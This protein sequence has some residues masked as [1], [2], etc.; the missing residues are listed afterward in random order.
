MD[1]LKLAIVLGLAGAS[2]TL[3]LVGVVRGL[4]RSVDVVDVPQIDPIQTSWPAA[5]KHVARIR[6][7]RGLAVG[8]SLGLVL[9]AALCLAYTCV[10]T[11]LK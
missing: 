7:R 4:G 5:D 10:A 3:I 6:Q 2:L 9:L 11:L 8:C 1:L